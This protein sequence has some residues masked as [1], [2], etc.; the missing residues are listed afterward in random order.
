M[1]ENGRKGGFGKQDHVFYDLIGVVC[2]LCLSSQAESYSVI[3][4]PAL[5]CLVNKELSP[6]DLRLVCTDVDLRETSA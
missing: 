6:L 5:S 3:T 2:T 1:V 4:F